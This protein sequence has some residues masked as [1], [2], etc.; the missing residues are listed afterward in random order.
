MTIDSDDICPVILLKVLRAFKEAKDKD[1]I[2]VKS[3][4]QA[5]VQE[6]DKWC[7]ETGNEYLG[8]NKDGEKYV[9][10][11]RVNKGE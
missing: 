9:V 11:I 4:W 2:I 6:L 1:E 7:R 5:V 10:R 8:W 3:K